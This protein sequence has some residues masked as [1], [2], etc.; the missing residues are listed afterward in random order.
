MPKTKNYENKLLNS[1]V[2]KLKKGNKKYIKQI[3]KIC[4]SKLITRSK[5]ISY[6]NLSCDEEDF[7]QEAIVHVLY[8]LIKRYKLNMK[9]GFS[10]YFEVG[11]H[12]FKVDFLKK[13]RRRNR[14]KFR[15]R[16]ETETFHNL[17]K[18]LRGHE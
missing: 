3:Y 10:R 7:I 5:S 9:T 17:S 6:V 4:L 8:R 13:Y 18:K 1:Y 11:I 16:D 14:D 2:R 15:K 12:N